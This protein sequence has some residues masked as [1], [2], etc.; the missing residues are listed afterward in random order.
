M[1]NLP[2]TLPLKSPLRMNEPFSV[3]PEVKHDEFVVKLKFAKATDP[4]L[5]LTVMVVPKVN[6]GEFP[7]LTRLAFQFPFTLLALELFE[8]HPISAKLIANRIAT[9]NCFIR[10]PPSRSPKG[11]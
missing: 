10:N 5:L 9:A 3:S 8:P 6:T 11:A 7:P 1:P 2:F 4:L